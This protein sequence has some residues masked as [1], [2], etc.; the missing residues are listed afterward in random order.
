MKSILL[1]SIFI[2]SF[3]LT[4][5]NPNYKE[6]SKKIM[7]NDNWSLISSEELQENGE[8]ISTINYVEDNWIKTSVPKTVL[9]ALVDAGKYE[10]IY[11]GKNLEAV[12]TKQFTVPWWYRKEFEITQKDI[13]DNYE[14]VFEG[15]NYKAN[16]WLNGNLVASDKD[17]EGAFGIFSFN[18]SNK[19]IPGKNVLAV[20]IIPPK[21]GDLT[22]GFVD[23]N[24]SPPDQN[25]GLWRGVILQKT[26]TVSLKN[27]FV[28]SKVNLETLDEAY[29][30]ING[31]LKNLSSNAVTAKVIGEIDQ[32]SFSKE[33]SLSPNE[34]KQIELSSKEIH[35][36]VFKNPK[37]W[38]PNNLGEQNLYNLNLQVIVNEVVSDKEEVTFG[39]REV[40][41]YKNENGHRGFKVNGK[42]VMIKSAGWVDDMLLNDSD[43]KVISQMEYAKHLNLNSIRLE[44]FWGKNKTLYQAADELG[45][46]LMIGWSCQWEWTGYCGREETDFMCIDTP[47]DMQLQTEA[48][49][50][51][52][53]WLRNHPSVLVWVFGSDKLPLPELER[54]LNDSINIYD[55]TRPILATCKG[56]DK[57]GYGNM[58]DVSG[59]PGVKMLGPYAYVTPNYWYEDTTNGGAYGFNTETG[60]G[61]QVPPIE[62]IKRMI[63]EKDLWPINEMWEYHCGRNEFNTLDRFL[64]IFN[65]RYGEAKT[66]EDFAKKTQVSNYEA[67]RPMFEAFGVN[68]HNTTGVVQWMYNSAWPEMFWQLFDHY[69]MPNGAFYGA[70]KACQPLNL[71]YNYKDKNIY[72]VNDYNENYNG[73][74]ANIK[75][76]NVNSKILFEKEVLFDALENSSMQVFDM[77]ELENLTKTYFINLELSDSKGNYIS[78]NFYWLSTKE[79][80]LD[81]EN[82]EWYYTPNKSLGDLTALNSLEV[83][84]VKYKYEITRENGEYVVKVNIDNASDKLAFFIEANIQD[85]ATQQSVLPIFWSDNY[86]SILPNES[87]EITGRFSKLS[88]MENAELVINGINTVNELIQK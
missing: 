26:K 81:F 59:D 68:K 47:Y 16:V 51:Q 24:P 30:I 28:K 37:L 80:V 49:M 12:D 53:K 36:L 54:M 6:G 3:M 40:E 62:S 78:D 8:A 76:I 21:S 34:E 11:F 69:L 56:V 31:E 50:D 72:L 73:L 19:V 85:K 45:L 35:E 70:K 64:S 4:N 22:I 27:V 48:Y 13:D 60:P 77:P 23:W 57:Y 39:I 43:E 38:W 29:L 41:D 33:I 7:L 9:A 17:I 63:P 20:E 88:A 55:P 46:L 32:K 2:F 67:I 10:D 14:I 66:L 58:S 18:I 71:V 61:P 79:D 86:V 44:G 74:K 1:T 15:I 82:V 52:V 65:V 75:V 87:K 5:C 83:A 25:M 42:K 84:E